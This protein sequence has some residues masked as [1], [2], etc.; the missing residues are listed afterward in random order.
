M[1]AQP[2]FAVPASRL[3]A[4]QVDALTA[5]HS[6]DTSDFLVTATPGAGKTTFALAVAQTLLDRR[7][8]DR[9]IVVCPTDHLRTQWADAAAR[10]GLDLDPA[11]SNA[12]GPVRPDVRGYV[13]TYAQVAGA[14]MLHRARTEA[15]RSLVI[16][17]EIHHAGDG[18]SWGEAVAEAF[19]PARRRLALTGTPFRTR[20][21]ERIPFVRYA[22][23]AV[24]SAEAGAPGDGGLASVAD[25]TYGYREALGDGVVRP[26]VFAAYTGVSR[27]RNSAGEVIAAS[28]TEAATKKTE[29][30]AWKTALN[31]RGRWV[32]HV[33]AAM[34]ERITHLRAHGMP[35]AAGLV[36]AS[37]QDDA[38][39]YAEIVERV[40]GARPAL[41]LSD[42]PNANARIKEF[43][44]SMERIAVCVRMI[45]EGVDVPRAACLA[46]MTSYRTPLFFAQAVGRVVR[47]RAA[48]ESATVFLPAVRPLLALAA[49]LEAERN[50]VIPPPSAGADGAW[51]E[52]DIERPDPV[53]GGLGYEALE[54]EAEFAHILHGGRAVIAEPAATD[55]D[56]DFLGLPGLLSPEQT[57]LLLA[58]RDH[59]LKRRAGRLVP[60]DDDEPE[61]AELAAY[62]QIATT[63]RRLSAM[64]SAH[65]L[66]T[67][68]PHGWIHSELRRRCGGPPTP[69]ATL[70][71]LEARI[72][73]LQRL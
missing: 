33:I 4:W 5:Y 34:D 38:R 55:A 16:L 56:E 24:T 53:G 31:P 32:P 59:D 52:L 73:M 29:A 8:V 20:P 28:L 71:Q 57:A 12:T 42:D 41:I 64:V 36:L 62:E 18:L 69:Q 11:L 37:D 26:V 46:W 2:D 45:S 30:A 61:P 70:E 65:S 25:F 67:G 17:D 58:R 22:E 54:S 60:A 66:A 68:R 49:E 50:H 1:S 51:D 63:R 6:A 7:A 47:A 40:T 21:D 9:V 48:H 43:T 10:T 14:P 3:R 44:H 72:A 23:A 35:D 27:W 13:T 15:K 19:T 39:A